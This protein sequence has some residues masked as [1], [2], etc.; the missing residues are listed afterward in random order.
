MYHVISPLESIHVAGRLGGSSDGTYA[1]GLNLL[2]AGK[3]YHPFSGRIQ[4]VVFATPSTEEPHRIPE[5]LWRRG[6]KEGIKETPLL[7]V[8]Y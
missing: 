5:R 4:G 3:L 8:P 1:G 7:T 6:Q 2:Q